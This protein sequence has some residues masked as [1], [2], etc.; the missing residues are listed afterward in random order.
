MK[1]VY[2]QFVPGSYQDENEQTYHQPP[3]TPYGKPRSAQVL[4]EL[5]TMGR[6]HVNYGSNETLLAASPVPRN[7]FG[8]NGKRRSVLALIPPVQHKSCFLSI[9]GTAEMYL[10]VQ[11][12]SP[13]ESTIKGVN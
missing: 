5:P 6:S 4:S 7:C 9:L 11:A 1:H 8:Y 2:S 12:L 10:L 13:A 3:S